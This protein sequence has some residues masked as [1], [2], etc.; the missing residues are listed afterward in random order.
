MSRVTDERS[1]PQD[2][3]VTPPPPPPPGPSPIAPAPAYGAA[4]PAYAPPP[5]TVVAGQTAQWRNQRPLT[6]A[7]VVILALTIVAAVVSGIA[8]LQRAAA[9]SD[10]VDHGLTFDRLHTASD[11]DDFVGAAAAFVA[12]C[13][14]VLLVLVIIW[15]WRAAKNVEALGRPNPRFTPGWGIAGW[16]IPFAN[17]VIPVLM[18]QDFWRASDTASPRGDPR[19]RRVRGSALVG[20]FWVAFLLSSVGRGWIGQTSA[21]YNDRDEL[22]DLATHDLFAAAGAVALV[23]AAI[24]AIL[25]YRKITARQEECLRAQQAAWAPATPSPS[26]PP[27]SS[28]TIPPTMVPPP[29]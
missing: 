12:L 25:V 19:W 11:A 15:S 9:L 1:D 23:A 3:A 21:H 26:S 17:L 8:Y 16:L 14:L 20:W 29:A 6:T 7:I 5:A 22:R 2:G 24:L 10:I 28:P 27:P 18:F 4:V 13:C